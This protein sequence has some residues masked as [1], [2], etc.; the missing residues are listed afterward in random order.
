M[1]QQTLLMPFAGAWVL[2]GRR[3][4][5]VLPLCAAGV[6]A[7]L[8]LRGS[9]GFLSAS[10]A[11]AA[12]LVAV[13]ALCALTGLLFYLGAGPLR[14]Q[15]LLKARPYAAAVLAGEADLFGVCPLSGQRPDRRCP[16]C[17]RF[18]SRNVFHEAKPLQIPDSF[19]VVADWASA[20]QAMV[21]QEDP[22]LGR[23]MLDEALD[24]EAN[25][26]WCTLSS[27]CHMCTVYSRAWR[28]LPMS[29]IIYGSAGV[30]FA[31]VPILGPEMFSHPGLAA[32]SALL[33]LF[34]AQVALLLAAEALASSAVFL[35]DFCRR[36]HPEVSRETLQRWE[37]TPW[38]WKLV[39]GLSGRKEE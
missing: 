10:A 18:V 4:L 12:V 38:Q 3:T 2:G 19:S 30:L 26:L 39:E 34:F 14:I 23:I 36:L 22:L 31:E 13:L 24:F 5:L 7:Q 37:L 28:V 27:C 35:R 32:G 11:D 15:P 25:L 16:I 1:V 8:A 33:S 29:A 17:S 6:A 9:P 21:R 20:R